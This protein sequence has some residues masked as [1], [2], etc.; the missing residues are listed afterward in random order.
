MIAFSLLHV[1]YVTRVGGDWMPYGRFLLPIFPL[2]VIIIIW[3]GAE[4][5]AL[6]WPR[7]HRGAW[8]LGA[9]PLAALLFVGK[10]C[11]SALRITR[12]RSNWS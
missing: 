9:L 7:L 2:V 3:G 4:L 12:R 1:A 10:R 11:C 6:G 8:L 5:I